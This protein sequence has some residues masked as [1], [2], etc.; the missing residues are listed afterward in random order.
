LLHI[1]STVSAVLQLAAALYVEL[2][3]VSFGWLVGMVLKWIE[4][5]APLHSFPPN[6]ELKP[7]KVFHGLFG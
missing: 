5:E 2:Q 3:A 4:D 6:F 7:D 1:H